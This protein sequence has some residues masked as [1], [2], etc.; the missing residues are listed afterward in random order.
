MPL[1]RFRVEE[2]NGGIPV[3]AAQHPV[4]GRPRECD[5]FDGRE[6]LQ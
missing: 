2:V 3:M 4:A 5:L 1:E 6:V